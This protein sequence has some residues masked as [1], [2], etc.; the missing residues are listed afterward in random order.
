VPVQK[1]CAGC[2]VQ[3]SVPPSHSFIKFHSQQCH[4]RWK[5]RSAAE[6]YWSH[7]VKSEIGCW[8]W[9]GSHHGAGYGLLWISDKPR[10]TVLAHRFSYELHY[11][12]I[13]EG[14][15]VLHS[16]DN[17]ECTRP[18]HLF[19]GTQVDNNND[20]DSKDRV[21]HGSEH[22]NAKL[23]EEQV[24]EIREIVK[25]AKEFDP[26]VVRVSLRSLARKYRVSHQTLADAVN[27]VTWKRVT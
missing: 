19:L 4:G 21:R 25:R 20:R 8:S 10:L 5:T 9:S 18:D 15:G 16:C 26:P 2:G 17:P 11:G 24:A 6:R 22:K 13:P 3:F 7:C 27:G 12:P 1:I 23:T 14:L